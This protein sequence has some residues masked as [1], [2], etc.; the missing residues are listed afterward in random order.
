MDGTLIDSEKLWDVAMREL[1]ESYNGVLSDATRDAT[2]GRATEQ[3]VPM[4]LEDLGVPLTETERAIRLL[5]DRVVELFSWGLEWRPGAPEL[6]AA[7]RAAGLRTA[8]VTNTGRR[9]V[10]QAL[11]N[12]M[13]G[14]T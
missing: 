1:A 7:V 2:I 3:A 12:V 4:M 11:S 10:E 9:L 14:G 6:I 5:T 8:L 13:Y